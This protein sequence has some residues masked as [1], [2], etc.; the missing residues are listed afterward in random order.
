MYVYDI[1]ETEIKI[2]EVWYNI[3]MLYIYEI[4]QA[5]SRFKPFW[6]IRMSERVMQSHMPRNEVIN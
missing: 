1:T 6:S 4:Q 2:K 5:F 3:F